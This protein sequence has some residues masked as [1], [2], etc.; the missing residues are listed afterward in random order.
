MISFVAV[1]FLPLLD[2]TLDSGTVVINVKVL[3]FKGLVL[4]TLLDLYF[5]P[6]SPVKQPDVINCPKKI[7]I[8]THRCPQSNLNLTLCL[9]PPNKDA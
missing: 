4:C 2:Y 8:T 3:V 9:R 1:F 5:S 7:K 6:Q